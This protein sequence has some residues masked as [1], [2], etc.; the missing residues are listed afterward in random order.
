MTIYALKPG[1]TVHAQGASYLGVV[2]ERAGIFEWN[3]E[4]KGI[5]WRFQEGVDDIESLER[6]LKR[7]ESCG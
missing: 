5:A 3:G 4:K 2:L 1:D 6:L 7:V